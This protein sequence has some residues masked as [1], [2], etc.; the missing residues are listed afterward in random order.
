MARRRHRGARRAS[1]LDLDAV[2]IVGGL[3]SPEMVARVAALDAGEITPEAFGVPPGLKLRDEI[4]RFFRVGE[5]L[6][7]QFE[8]AGRGFPAAET[9]VARLFT[10]CL[11]FPALPRREPVRKGE[12]VF[13]IRHIGLDGRV[14]VV[15]A[16]PRASE[17]ERDGIDELREAFADEGRR[18]T[19]TTLLQ[20]Y[21][22]AEESALWGIACDGSKL[23]LMRD[24]PSLTR[25]AWIEFDLERIFTEKLFPDFTAF[26]TLLHASRFGVPG[27]APSDCP[28][29]RWRDQGRVEGAAAR[30]KLRDGVEN[31]LRDLGEGFLA[32][33]ES[34]ALR[35]DLTEG[36]LSAQGYFEELLKVVYRLIFL[37]AAEDRDLLHP[38]EAT[39]E[40]RAL[41]REGYSVA[42]LRE[43][44]TRRTAWDRHGDVWEGLKITFAALAHGQ[45]A[46]GLAPLGG[47]FAQGQTPHLRAAKI[48]NRYLLA[49]IW[50]LA[51]FRPTGDQI[52][53]VNWRDME[54]EELGSV[55]ES[56]LEL[57]PR[58]EPGA[59]G[60]GFADD[61][62]GH[63]RKTTGSYYTPDA[64]VKLL[65]DTTLDPVL[66][67]AE[68]RSPEDPVAEIL[69]L[70]IIDPA[71][72]SG[73][74][75]LGA[76]R[77]AAMRIAR[78]R[79]GG[80]P[81]RAAE[82]AALRDVVSHCIY[83]VDRN[84]MAV[85]LCKVALWIEA[86]EP[87]KPLTFLD[88]RI[89]CG[90]SL[91]GVYDYAQLRRGLPDA[92][93][94][95][96]TGDDKD[97]AKA[98]RKFNKEQREGRAAT[99]FIAGLAA[100]K[101]LT[102]GAEAI[103]AMPEDTLEQSQRKA[104]AFAKLHEGNAWLALKTACDLYVAAFLLPKTGPV[105]QAE[106]L[107]TALVPTTETV[108][109]AARGDLPEGRLMGVATDAAMGADA[110][111]WPLEFP[112]VF[113]HGGFDAVVGNPPWERIKL[114]EQEFFA[115][116]SPEI[117]SASNKA[118]RDR[119][120]RAL[121]TAEEGSPERRL[122]AEFVEA[123]RLAEAQ[124]VFARSSGRFPLTGAGDV[125]TY[126]LFA[127]HFS[128]LSCVEIGRAGVIVPTGIATDSTTA[129]FFGSLIIQNQLAALF[130]F[131]E[132]RRWFPATDDRKAFCVLTIGRPKREAE[133]CF[134]IQSI[135][136]LE[137]PERR[138]ALTADQIARINPNTRT[139]PIFRS[140]ADAE[141][142]AKLYASKP[143]L[144]EERPD[145]E[146]GDLNPWG[147]TFHTRV[148]HMAEDAHWFKD[149]NTLIEEGWEW[150]GA[151][152]SKGSGRRLPLYE[153]KMAHLFDH[154]WATY[155]GEDEE[156]G[157]R[158]ATL[159]EKQDPSFEP[160]PRYWVPEAEVRLRGSR[161][162][163]RLK[164]AWRKQEGD[165]CLAVLSEWLL[166]ALLAEGMTPAR[167]ADAIE[168]ELRRVLGPSAIDAT[169]LG[170]PFNRWL[171]K[172]AAAAPSTHA[173][174]P[175]L[176][177]DRLFLSQC[178]DDPLALTWAVI[179]RKQPRW[180]MGWRDICR[181]T[182]ERTVVAFMLPPYANNDKILVMYPIAEPHLCAALIANLS[183]L[184]IDFCAR[185]KIGGTSFKLYYM[186]QMPL[187]RPS[188]FTPDDLVYLT[189]RV[190]E[191]TYTSH[192]M[193][194]WAE[195][196][197]YAGAPYAWDEPRRATL[198]A[199]ID[200]FFAR[201]YGLTRDELRYVLDPAD[202]RGPDYPSE[203]FR[204]LKKNEEARYG[205][206]RTRRLVLE[207]FDRLTGG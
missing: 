40:V 7:D 48:Q 201:K 113:A 156:S 23:R 52:T 97:V 43:R 198:R 35:A 5:T 29:E 67:A 47:L 168:R 142:S 166:G 197:G 148:W 123:K 45:P 60:F 165:R 64:L 82:Q 205:E 130:S 132:I 115:A 104:T 164:S 122:H 41:Y 68:A 89:R 10:L 149:K 75:L 54:T 175:L 53:R 206:Y 1:R 129:P 131:Y 134:D 49:A 106:G 119:L 176:A 116:R 17:T 169:V 202:A 3:L 114:Q 76:A 194:H 24:N 188:D 184:C 85:E 31:A 80:A 12:R 105:P 190:L 204:V 196:L 16:A 8:A 140:R 46:L 56:L 25:A 182:D 51:W 143:V 117:A 138:F 171:T 103:L 63:A 139:A 179:L 72:G 157:A 160:T 180:L 159:A 20:E 155:V 100:P 69:R 107:S 83:G 151:T 65:L 172:S 18:R 170:G 93:F 57:T 98:F 91:I 141:L 19:A 124:S 26:W 193:R 21:L 200:A 167:D 37:F 9:F 79:T 70:S 38:A 144:I 145:D 95:A 13:P 108:W 30:D 163:A 55:Y 42:R 189:P 34:A 121:E 137:H 86:L 109:R 14:P 178:G 101:D 128:R 2:A 88:A 22:N 161:V 146:G 6:W 187:F 39:K 183:S 162:P 15:I 120:I 73:H 77:R 154:R 59:R 174:T 153:A 181:S 192:A 50:R 36:R 102:E 185:Q 28:L 94:D 133:F 199:E 81:S 195:D 186:K 78:H 152:W 62:G 58:V 111:H 90:D 87:G 110:F 4:A 44:C 177:D 61:V 71:C 150:H 203:T 136:D 32:H 112:Q 66:D 207:A 27:A 11:G 127:E 135:T 173:S 74:F 191:L 96:L 158:N 126:A 125:N 84:P 118:A 99:G 147:I 33:P 92:A